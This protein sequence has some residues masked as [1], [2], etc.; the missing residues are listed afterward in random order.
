MK[1]DRD[2]FIPTNLGEALRKYRMKTGLTQKSVAEALGLSRSAYTYYETGKTSPDPTMLFRIARM[3]DVPL[4]MFFEDG[5]LGQRT[6]VVMRDSGA[7]EK[8]KRVSKIV[9]PDPQ[10]IGELTSDEK[11]MIAFLRSRGLSVREALERLKSWY[12]NGEY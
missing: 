1:N 5:E 12:S 8:R 4:D 3:F 10:K 7:P 11:C 9:R 2:D 6:E